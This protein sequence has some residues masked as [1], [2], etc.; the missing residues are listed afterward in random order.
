MYQCE[1]LESFWTGVFCV[2]NAFLLP[3]APSKRSI[4]GTNWYGPH[5]LEVQTKRRRNGFTPKSLDIYT[6]RAH[7]TKPLRPPQLNKKPSVPHFEA[8]VNWYCTLQA[9]LS[10]F[11]HGKAH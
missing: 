1:S 5:V 2:D 8:I 11:S 9:L 10:V 4:P 6:T 3:I 7:N